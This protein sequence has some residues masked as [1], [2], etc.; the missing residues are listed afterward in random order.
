MRSRC[1]AGGRPLGHRERLMDLYKTLH[2]KPGAS[3]EAVRA[4]FRRQAGKHHPDRGGSTSKYQ[5]I[6]L[7]Y[8][9]L[10]DPAR[11]AHY[12]ATGE[13]LKQVVDTKI[14]EIAQ[15]IGPVLAQVMMQAVQ[16]RMDL[17]HADIIKTLGE[18]LNGQLREMENK[19]AQ[20]V[21][22]RAVIEQAKTRF[23]DEENLL[24]GICDAHI[25]EIDGQVKTGDKQYALIEDAIQYLKKCKYSHEPMM[26]MRMFGG[27]TANQTATVSSS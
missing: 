9:V 26:V 7:A 17:K 16:Q 2:L 18:Q 6:Q 13:I 10:S 24:S 27:W 15:V 25:R 20:V 3:P 12:D 8:E 14:G 5:E 21:K 23:S 1:S 11:R 4:A 19:K 22:A